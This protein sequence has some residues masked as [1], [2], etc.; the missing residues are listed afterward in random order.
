MTQS[1]PP[2]LDAAG[3]ARLRTLSEELR[4]LVCQNQTLADSHAD[5]AIDLRNQVQELIAA[6][7]TNAEIKQYLVE[8]YGDFVL[9][10]PPVQANTAL[11][12]GGP[13]ALLAGGGLIWAI[14]Q[15]R[16]RLAAGPGG[17]SPAAKASVSVP[18]LPVGNASPPGR[19][20]AA[21]ETGRAEPAV[22]AVAAGSAGT[23]A[24]GQAAAEHGQAGL[25]S[26]EREAPPGA[27][28]S[29]DA[30]SRGVAGTAVAGSIVAG[31]AVPGAAGMLT[32]TRM[33]PP[34][35]PA[36]AAPARAPDKPAATGLERARRLL[37]D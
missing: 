13:F 36:P 20:G 28:A 23:A 8:R 15:R 34:A 26:S 21:P 18:G 22:K 6:G 19:T 12:W 33:T 32:A 14:V 24:P 31:S 27:P 9:Y 37:D 30:G 4:C 17:Q 11:L 25:G 1:S 3:Q 7:K 16:S 29:A 35:A 2:P 10:R 5:L